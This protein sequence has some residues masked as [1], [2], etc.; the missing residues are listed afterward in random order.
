MYKSTIS[1]VLLAEH[2]EEP[3][4]MNQHGTTEDAK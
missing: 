2:E 3:C 4:N 1:N